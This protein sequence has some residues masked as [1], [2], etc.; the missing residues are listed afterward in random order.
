MISFVLI[1]IALRILILTDTTILLD[2][3]EC[4]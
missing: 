1:A 4:H 3:I 2:M